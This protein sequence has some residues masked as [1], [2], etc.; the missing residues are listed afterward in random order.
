VDDDR[1]RPAAARKLP[2]MT[3]EIVADEVRA[4]AA[5][6]RDAAGEADV[7]GVRLDG[8][9]PVG[10]TLQPSVEAFLEC[11]RT[12]GIAL[13]GELRW[14][15]STVAAVADSWVRLDAAIVAPA[16]RRPPA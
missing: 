16:G 9:P 3:I 15:G 10:G 14:L 2:G 6:L 12:A 8:T 11:H 7:I 5:T 1:A 13:A 4:L